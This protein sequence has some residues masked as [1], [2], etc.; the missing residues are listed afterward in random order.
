M[1]LESCVPNAF[2]STL[3]LLLYLLLL[4]VVLIMVVCYNLL[5]FSVSKYPKATTYVNISAQYNAKPVVK[6]HT[7]KVNKL[8]R[9]SYTQFFGFVVAVDVVVSFVHHSP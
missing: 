5:A 1:C 4:L 7:L 2:I 6:R 3:F 9:M 8:Q